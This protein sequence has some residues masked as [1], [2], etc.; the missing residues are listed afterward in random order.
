MRCLVSLV[1]LVGALAS[2]VAAHARPLRVA[3]TT[4]NLGSIA[5]AVGGEEVEVTTFARGGQDPH[6]VE[7]RPSFIRVLSRTDLFV[8]VGLQLELGW[9]PP[10]LRNARNAR[11]QPGGVGALD[12]SEGIPLLGVAT[13]VVDRSQGDVHAAGNP[14]YL[15]DPVNGIRVARAIRDKLVVLRPEG[16]ATFR[17]NATAFE[18]A[19][20][21]HLFGPEAVAEHG[22]AVLA[23][24]ALANR[25]DELVPEDR[26]GGWLGRMRPHR[27]ATAIADHNIWPYFAKRF[28]FEVIGFLE[29][30]PGIAPT[31]RHLGEVAEQ[32]KAAG[33]S[34]ILSAAYFHPRYAEKV[35]SATGASV[36]FM[37]DQVGAREGVDDYIAMIDWNVRRLAD[38]L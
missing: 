12:A 4:P 17:A 29:P 13:G 21:Q 31:T 19:V 22:A 5:R 7:P 8:M 6:F 14:H 2:A 15:T 28:G 27:G 24:A 20:T 16:E 26:L 1:V 23:E 32:M 38:A 37:A 34:V 11:I 9:V 33:T 35:A 18:A 25:S 30:F 10:L 3:T 36:V